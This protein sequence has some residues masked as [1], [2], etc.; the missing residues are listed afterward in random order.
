MR[1]CWEPQ[2]SYVYFS[3]RRPRRIDSYIT[4]SS[5]PGATKGAQRLEEVKGSCSCVKH[6]ARRVQT[7]STQQWSMDCTATDSDQGSCPF[8]RMSRG[9]KTCQMYL[10]GLQR[11]GRCTL[12]APVFQAAKASSPCAPGAWQ[13][14]RCKDIF[15]FLQKNRHRHTRHTGA[16]VKSISVANEPENIYMSI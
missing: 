5:S 4:P 16:N 1:S 11:T 15:R 12:P 13:M 7:V 14:P 6:I 3:S 8:L 9:V 2:S 10:P